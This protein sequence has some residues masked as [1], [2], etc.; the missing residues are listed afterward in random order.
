LVAAFFSWRELRHSKEANHLRSEANRFR[1]DANHWSEE[2]A[3]QGEQANLAHAEANRL[4]EQANKSVDRIA[5]N[6]TPTQ[7]LANRNAD[8]LRKYLR[9]T[10]KVSEVGGVGGWGTTPEIVNVSE[11]NIVTLFNP[12]GYSSTTATAVYVQCDELHIVEEPIGACAVQIKVLKRYADTLQ[13]GE[14]RKWEDRATPS[15]KPLPRG[16]NVHHANFT[17]PGSS[18]RRS[19]H[20]YAPTDGNPQ[21]TLATIVDGQ[22]TGV[23]YGSSGVE[24]SKKFAILQIDWR[25]EGFQYGGGG[26]G[27]SAER[28]FLFTN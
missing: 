20:I 23:L 11:D 24:I 19:I 15:S 1:E 2:A 28:L 10:A 8:K 18:Q 22:E 14:I 16:A 21:Y 12:A 17:L 6:T 5:E 13:L 9:K 26:S 3:R 25:A 4:R 27:G 7:T